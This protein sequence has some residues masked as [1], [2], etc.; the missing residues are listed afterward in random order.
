M[1]LL[2]LFFTLFVVDAMLHHFVWFLGNKDTLLIIPRSKNVDIRQEL[3]KFHAK[4][5]SANIM[6]LAVLGRG[7]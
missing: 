5:Y 7:K 4:F 1:V 3:L 2:M 6:S